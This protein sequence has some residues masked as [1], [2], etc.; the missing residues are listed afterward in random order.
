MNI[1]FLEIFK[2]SFTLVILLLCSVLAVTAFIERWW[3]IRK[4]SIDTSKFMEK[5]ELFIEKNAYDEAITHCDKNPVPI[6]NVIR[7]GIIN[8]K[9]DKADIGELMESK[10]MEERVKMDSWLGILGTLGNVAP[11]IGLFGTV[12]GI[13]KA[14]QDLALAGGGGPAVVA[15]G[16]AE[17]LVATAAGLVVA[18]PAVIIYNYF[19]RK[20]KSL[21]GGM[22]VA[23][24]RLLVM[25]GSK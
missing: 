14:F 25:L 18:I 3:Y 1:D 8:R 2:S 9:K 7:V 13:I 17:A 19:T 23:S 11:F 4:C 15:R 5:I 24:T 21:S 20:V 16:I 6:S 12:V 22:E 10:K